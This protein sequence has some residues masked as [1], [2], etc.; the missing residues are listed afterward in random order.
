MEDVLPEVPTEDWNLNAEQVTI[1]RSSIERKT[2]AHLAPTVL[3]I[4]G[5][6]RQLS[7]IKK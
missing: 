5:E 2:G 7:C 4:S 3:L 6:K 1:L